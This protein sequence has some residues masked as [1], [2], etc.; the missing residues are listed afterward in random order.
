MALEIV[1]RDEELAALHQFVVR[2]ANGPAAL[3][4]SGEA[5]IGKSTLWRAGVEAAREQGLRVLT[6]RPTEAE[7]PL[8]LT[9]L[10]DL[11][12]GVAQEVLPELT[13]PQRRA[14]EVALLIDEMPGRADPRAL[15]VAVRS[16]LQRLSRDEPLV[17]A[18]DDVQWLDAATASALE[19]GLRRLRDEHVLLLLAR[20]LGD[21]ADPRVLEETLGTDQTERLHVRPLSMG[22][23]HRLVQTRLGQTF[24]RPALLRLHEVSGGNPFYALEL[25]RG[26]D[27][28]AQ[29]VP[30]PETLAGLVRRRLA[31]FPAETRE[32][33]LAL[34]VS[35][36]STLAALEVVGSDE[37]ALAPA[38]AADVIEVVGDEVRFTHPLLSSTVYREAPAAERRAF[39]GRL[40]QV[41]TEPVARA[42]HLALAD[43]EPGEG[44]ARELEQAASVARARGAIT[45]AAELAE[46]AGRRTPADAAQ[47][48]HRRLLQAAR[49]HVASGTPGKARSLGQEVL[50]QAAPGRARARR[51]S[52]CSARSG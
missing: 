39:H 35:S 32:A 19:F 6:A 52:G 17:L 15:G 33:L 10:G 37:Q 13:A 41:V 23:I 45:V 3:V 31:P 22:A 27:R 24:A 29:V 16:S 1:G 7:K 5:G 9:G 2:P 42:R 26:L 25:A 21:Y 28:A 20:R 18:V 12:D 48:A 38:L 36:R 50:A 40:A 47:D 43:E 8:A 49:D 51:R 46:L 14:L 11:L 34:A 30:I 44:V 4:L